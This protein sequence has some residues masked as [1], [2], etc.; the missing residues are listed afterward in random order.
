MREQL[1]LKVDY[2]EGIF[3]NQHTI[4]FENFNGKREEVVVERQWVTYLDNTTGLVRLVGLRTKREE[5]CFR[6]G[7]MNALAHQI[8]QHSVAPELVLTQQE[9]FE[10]TIGP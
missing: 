6:A 1:Y 8:T 2:A 10:K 4:S 3:P 7:I 9:Y 5:R